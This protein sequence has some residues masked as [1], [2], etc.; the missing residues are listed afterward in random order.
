MF[1]N[2]P[3]PTKIVIIQFI[4]SLASL[5]VV[6]IWRQCEVLSHWLDAR[7]IRIDPIWKCVENENEV[8]K[9]KHFDKWKLV[10]ETRL[11]CNPEKI[12]VCF[13]NKHVKNS[14]NETWKNG[15]CKSTFLW[16]TNDPARARPPSNRV[17]K[18]EAF[19]P[20]TTRVTVDV[21]S[22]DTHGFSLERACATRWQ[23]VTVGLDLLVARWDNSNNINQIVLLGEK[24]YFRICLMG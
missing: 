7:L 23:I 17:E 3:K 9:E 11:S 21:E 1:L 16:T 5:H 4:I 10:Y 22:F 20:V 8:G 19:V 13:E 6:K 12:Q 18:A 2:F 15:K 14:R 24:S